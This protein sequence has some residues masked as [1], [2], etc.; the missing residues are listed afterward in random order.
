MRTTCDGTLRVRLPSSLMQAVAEVSAKEMEPA[1]TFVRRA[2]L[3]AV[4]EHG[5]EPASHGE[6][7]K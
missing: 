6:R 5:V 2:L 4:R 3:A 7:G 1:S